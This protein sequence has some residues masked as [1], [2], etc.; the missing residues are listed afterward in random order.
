[1]ESV[2]KGSPMLERSQIEEEIDPE[3]SQK[4]LSSPEANKAGVGG[5]FDRYR[6]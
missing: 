2:H 6:T 1:M 4:L 3:M 5:L